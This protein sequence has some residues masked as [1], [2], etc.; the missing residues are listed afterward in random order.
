MRCATADTISRGRVDEGAGDGGMIREAEII[1]AAE[2]DQPLGHA[3][4]ARAFELPLL[5]IG[6]GGSQ[7]CRVALH[8]CT[9]RG[10]SCECEQSGPC[11]CGTVSL[12][13]AAVAASPGG[14]RGWIPRRVMSARSR[15]TSGLPVVSSFSP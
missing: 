4:A 13:V 10:V 5:E 2:V 11:T 1:V 7:R 9:G 15:A 8:A 14:T 3:D 6:E 12:S